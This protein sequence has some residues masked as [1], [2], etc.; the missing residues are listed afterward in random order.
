MPN[1]LGAIL[2]ALAGGAKGY[3]NLKQREREEALEAERRAREEQDRQEQKAFQ[4]FTMERELQKMGGRYTDDMGPGTRNPDAPSLVKM[5]RVE[6]ALLG[7]ANALPPRADGTPRGPLKIGLTPN[8]ANIGIDLDKERVRM[9]SQAIEVPGS[10]GRRVYL[11]TANELGDQAF[12][13]KTLENAKE[14]G[15]LSANA[16]ALRA[17]LKD[18]SGVET[19]KQF[20]KMWALAQLAKGTGPGA[21]VAKQQFA[22]QY[23]DAFNNLFPKPFP[24]DPLSDVGVAA[25]IK[26]NNAKE[27]SKGGFRPSPVQIEKLGAY[28]AIIGQAEEVLTALEGAVSTETD[29]T[30]RALGFVPLPA[31]TKNL[32]RVGGD[33]GEDVRALIGN[34]Y[35]TL[36]KER[37]GTALSATELRL[38]ES[39]VPNQNDSEASGVIK[40]KRFINEMKRIRDAKL[41][42]MIKYGGADAERFGGGQNP[43]SQTASSETKEQM[44][45]RLVNNGMSAAAATA[46]VRKARP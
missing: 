38:L 10:G 44:W 3:T 18:E 21:A 16:T 27:G 43:Q 8:A 42:A 25:Q 19:D 46:A 32:F 4:Q 34:M 15:V 40:A 28:D 26:I 9:A 35:G 31:W 30:G 39:Y 12:A 6:A 33:V 36:A 23:P 11:P 24:V 41:A 1:G 22:V 14:Q 45:D 17:V 29:A 13:R 7:T 2:A 37:G 5:D 20:Q